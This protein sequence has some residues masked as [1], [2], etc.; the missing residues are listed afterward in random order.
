MRFRSLAIAGVMLALLFACWAA[1]LAA[2]AQDWRNYD[3]PEAGFAVHFPA[4][5]TVTHGVYRTAAGVTAPSTIYSVRQDDMVYT[6]TTADFSQVT[7]APDTVIGDAVKAFGDG[8]EIK[9]D[10]E[11]RINRQ[12]GHELSVGG[13]D[14]SRS[15]V[16]IFFFN[17]RFYQL[18]GKALPPNSDARSSKLIR[19]QQS[20]QFPAD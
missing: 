9:V 15:T 16:A 19:F 8:G 4:P 6:V 11:A 2:H 20:L 5:P 17:H 7:I 1:P 14:G 3:Y 10:V 18:H 13:K 12:Y